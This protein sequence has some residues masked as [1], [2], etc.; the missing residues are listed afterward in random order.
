LI[1][2]SKDENKQQKLINNIG[3]EAVTD[4]DEKI[5]RKILDHIKR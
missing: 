1:A 2:L 3:R 5:A 4:A